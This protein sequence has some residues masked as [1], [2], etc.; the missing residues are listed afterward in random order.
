MED[1]ETPLET[2][3]RG[4]KEEFGASGQ[5]IAFLGCLSGLLPDFH[6][7][8]EKTTLYVACQLIHWN[9]EERDLADPEAS[10]T[11][12][13]LEPN[14]IISLMQEQGRRFPTRIDANESEIIKRAIPYIS[15]ALDLPA[16]ENFKNDEP[17]S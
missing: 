5:P 16:S 14:T 13:W 12:E 9:P 11:I 8:F 15:S 10:S 7:T 3:S 1:N 2:V 4:L 6:L 17:S